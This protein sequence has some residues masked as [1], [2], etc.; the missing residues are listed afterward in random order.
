MTCALRWKT[1][2]RAPSAPASCRTGPKAR[3]GPSP[4]SAHHRTS[5]MS[6]QPLGEPIDHVRG[7]AVRRCVG[8][9]HHRADARRRAH[10]ALDRVVRDGPDRDQR[11]PCRSTERAASSS[12][13]RRPCSPA[14]LTHARTSRALLDEQHVRCRLVPLAVHASD[15]PSLGVRIPTSVRRYRLVIIGLR[16]A[17]QLLLR[18]VL[19]RRPDSA[20]LLHAPRD[21]RVVVEPVGEPLAACRSR[22]RARSDQQVAEDGRASFTSKLVNRPPR[23][24][25]W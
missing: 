9:H 4:A 2:K 18:L 24:C 20:M 11:A 17:Q 10:H 5:L 6:R 19:Q 1:P 22:P 8:S 3:F 16:Q 25:R 12:G 15:P 13:R 14:A 23:P 7:S 21:Q